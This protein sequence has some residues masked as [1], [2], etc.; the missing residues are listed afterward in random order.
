MNFPTTRMRRLR[1]SSEIR[2]IFKETKLNKEDLI[3]PIFVKED[4]KN[5]EKEALNTMPGQFR[6]SIDSAL[7]FGKSLE[8]NGLKSIIIFGL[9]S[10]ETKNKTGSPAF[11]KDGVVQK[12]IKSFK[13]ETNL[14]VISDVCLCQYISHG[15]CGLLDEKDNNYHVNKNSFEIT[16]KSIKRVDIDG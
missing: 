4:L 11:E 8:S 1:K 7:E 5:D 6:Y 14:V 13:D 12:T 9:P 15:H 10:D 16:E 3:Y 2:D